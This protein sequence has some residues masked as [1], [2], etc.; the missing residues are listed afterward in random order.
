MGLAGA[1][2]QRDPLFWAHSAGSDAQIFSASSSVAPLSPGAVGMNLRAE[3]SDL[4]V[5]G[6]GLRRPLASSSRACSLSSSKTLLSNTCEWLVDGAARGRFPAVSCWRNH[7]DFTNNRGRFPRMKSAFCTSLQE[8]P[9][10][11]GQPR[12][13]VDLLC[14]VRPS[15]EPCASPLR[16]RAE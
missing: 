8:R 15:P 7:P 6:P 4:Q 16:C 3:V 13:T 2:F 11:F 10:L 9:A 14:P 1:P 12:R 5:V